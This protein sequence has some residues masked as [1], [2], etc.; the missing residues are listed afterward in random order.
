MQPEIQRCIQDVV[1]IADALAAAKRRP[2]A[3]VPEALNRLLANLAGLTVDVP[4]E[5]EAYELARR[6]V[7]VPDPEAEPLKPYP[8]CPECHTDRIAPRRHYVVLVKCGHH[9]RPPV[10]PEAEQRAALQAELD[11]LQAQI[12]AKEKPRLQV[13][14]AAPAPQP[15]PGK[16]REPRMP[17]IPEVVTML[18]RVIRLKEGAANSKGL[19]ADLAD[20]AKAWLT[21]ERRERKRLRDLALVSP[22][23]RERLAERA[24]EK[25][26]AALPGQDPA[27]IGEPWP[28]MGEWL[29]CDSWKN[30]DTY[31]GKPCPECG[32]AKGEKHPNRCSV[33]G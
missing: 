30:V 7:E 26:L 1:V 19:P 29:E 33:R 3:V 10:D 31:D 24:P 15:R 23:Y 21:E 22:V 20:L 12:A 17:T 2:P 9:D 13:V 11:K 8:V 6:T 32:R 14:R 25:L 27:T 16:L 18:E 4:A 5:N 28:H